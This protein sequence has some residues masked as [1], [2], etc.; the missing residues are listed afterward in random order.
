VTDAAFWGTCWRTVQAVAGQ[1]HLDADTYLAMVRSEIPSYDDLQERLADATA[2][3]KAR[4]I[5][6]LG[7]G[8]GVTA[9]R[10]LARHPGATLVGV[11]SN[12]EMLIHAKRAVPQATF[13][14]GHLED[15]LPA[16]PFDV[17]VS[18]FAI[19]HLPS[20][21]KADLFERVAA[22][23]SAHGCF[24]FCDVVVP[25]APVTRPV[26]IEEGVDLPDTAVD[27]VRWLVEAGLQAS[28]VFAEADLAILRAGR[29]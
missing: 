16:G 18:A 11:D 8:T 5:L 22:V 7:S 15:P 19:H 26:P 27:Q 14:E 17:V 3:V 6:D 21:A 25:T 23:L 9:G 29:T 10:V 20:A 13:V 12:P 28:I 2:D 1:W 24:V 4:T